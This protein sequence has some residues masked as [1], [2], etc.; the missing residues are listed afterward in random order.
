MNSLFQRH[1]SVL[2]TLCICS[3][4][5]TAQANEFTIVKELKFTSDAPD[6]TLDLYLPNNE[7]NPS[8]C[9]IVIQGG[10]FRPQ[11][12]NRFRSFAEHLASNGYAAALISYRGSP[13]H[14]H[15]DT[16]ADVKE[17]VRYIRR[18]GGSH[19][20]D[21]E[22]IGAMGRSAGGTLAAL[23]AVTSDAAD[24]QSRIKAAVCFAGV[25]DFIG[26][27]TD[28]E[29]L[30]LQPMHKKKLQSNGKWIGTPFSTDDK[31]WLDASA[32]THVDADDPPILFLHSKD[33]STVPWIQSRDMH[34]AMK[35]V[36]VSTEMKIY[37]T[38]GHGVNPKDASSL[39]DMVTF[40]RDHL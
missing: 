24:G 6:L 18:V 38:G 13:K 31:D 17:S 29:Q 15:N 5:G 35:K 39:D 7:A 28:P 16:L 36:G 23:L 10:G 4:F 12:G 8:P 11:N 30:S 3:T 22:R 21:T 40:F 1:L 20:I 33:D 27:F 19:N 32:I 9:V 25:F 34:R 2:L 26:R 37:E 14:Q